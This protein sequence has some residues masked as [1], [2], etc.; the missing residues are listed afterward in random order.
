MIYI[1]S[2]IVLAQTYS[3]FL[4]LRPQATVSYI[5]SNKWQFGKS[6]ILDDIQLADVRDIPTSHEIPV[7]K[8]LLALG[9]GGKGKRL[10]WNWLWRNH[11]NLKLIYTKNLKN[12]QN[13][14]R[15]K[16]WWKKEL[17]AYLLALPSISALPNKV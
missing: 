3:N 9:K 16:I 10:L 12:Y 11:I 2:Y 13:F 7:L 4:R 5:D 6:S 8:R 14:K 17:S 1:E 15:K